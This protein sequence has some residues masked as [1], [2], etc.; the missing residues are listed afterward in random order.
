MV[1]RPPP[2]IPRRTGNANGQRRLQ[3]LAER[4]RSAM[5]AGDHTAGAGFAE[6]ALKLVPNDFTVLSDYALCLM[7]TRR[8]EE[9]YAVYRKIFD[10]APERQRQASET[11]LDGLAE[12]CGWLGRMGELREYGL[13]A[14]EKD[15]RRFANGKAFELPGTPPPFDPTRPSEN[16]VVYTLF[17]SSP[18]YCESMVLNARVCGELFPGWTCRVYL[19]DSVPAHVSSRLE[20]AGAQLVRM[21]GS[22]DSLPALTWRFLVVDDA[23]VKRFLIRDADSLLSEREQ[24]A[25]DEW[26]RSGLWFHHMRDYFTHTALVLA[27]TWGGCHGALGNMRQMIAEYSSRYQDKARFVDQS[28]LREC[29]W[30]T[31]RKSLLSHDE[32]FG[33]HDARPFPPHSPIRWSGAAFHVG[34]NASYQQVGATSTLTDGKLQR[35]L[36]EDKQGPREYEAAVRNGQWRLDLPFFL[37][38]AYSAG[39]LKITALEG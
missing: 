16:V 21:D 27:G 17:G 12:V 11:W 23:S 4:F 6:Q 18:R 14:L 32:L 10:A 15:D 37:V 8:Y 38:E 3:E 9:A 31:M 25:V 20:A 36:F 29:V 35:V 30:P 24:A 5:A 7:R 19:D 26:L 34:S 13:Q 2:R 22:D 33:F 39:R 1:R 28:F